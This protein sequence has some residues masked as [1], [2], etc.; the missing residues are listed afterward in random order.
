MHYGHGIRKSY[1]RIR[2]TKR[3]QYVRITEIT[4]G[5]RKTIKRLSAL[6]VSY[7]LDPIK[8]QELVE[9]LQICSASSDADIKRECE[10]ISK[11]LQEDL[12]KILLG[13]K[14]S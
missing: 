6:Y 4:G 9:F 7:T 12:I 5:A 2:K 14:N 11:R 10:L 3:D 13:N 1:C 8:Y